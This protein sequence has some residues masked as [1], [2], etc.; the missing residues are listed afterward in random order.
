MI[1]LEIDPNIVKPG[2]TP[3][4]ITIAIAAVM[5]FGFFSMRRQ[6]RRINLPGD[7][8]RLEAGGAG[9][10]DESAHSDPEPSDEVDPPSPGRTSSPSTAPP[11]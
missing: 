5:V 10:V 8:D 3:L 9:R 7:A 1:F 11:G 4:L 6:F 2:W